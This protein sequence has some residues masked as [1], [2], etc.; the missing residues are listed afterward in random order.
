[1][2]RPDS[3]SDRPDPPLLRQIR[4][5]LHL[6][7]ALQALPRSVTEAAATVAALLLAAAAG[8]RLPIGPAAGVLDRLASPWIALPLFAA[9]LAI[10]LGIRWRRTAVSPLE[11]AIEVDRRLGL[12]ERVSSATL[13][14]AAADPAV[15]AWVAEDAA[16]RTAGMTAARVAP[17]SLPRGW[18]APTA[19]IAAVA[20]LL[21]VDPPGRVPPAA[22]AP[23]ASPAA[24]AVTTQLA[25]IREAI[26]EAEEEPL[27][28]PSPEAPR[29]AA[30]MEASI[31][32]LEAEASRLAAAADSG[33][34]AARREAIEAAAGLGSMAERLD[35][36]ATAREQ[37]IESFAASFEGLDPRDLPP[38]AAG[39]A[40][41]IL[42]GDFDAAAETLESLAGEGRPA[43]GD[44]AAAIDAMTAALAEAADA[45][46]LEPSRDAEV[47]RDEFADRFDA[48]ENAEGSP[49]APD[50]A[51]GL[52]D[53]AGD[54]S[55]SDREPRSSASQN[56]AD[57][58]SETLQ[59]GPE[60]PAAAEPSGPAA[61]PEG[62]TAANS[63]PAAP[64]EPSWL[65]R[66]AE[67]LRDL[68]P[69]PSPA[70]TPAPDATGGAENATEPRET[71][72]NEA[73]EGDASQGPDA[74]AP[75]ESTPAPSPASPVGTPSQ[76]PAGTPPA[77]T[78]ASSPASSDGTSSQPTAGT[79]PSATPAPSP[80]SSEGVASQSP[81][82]TPP[83]ASGESTG[84]R[85]ADGSAS[86]TA[87]PSE[88]PSPSGSSPVARGDA[89]SGSP[90]SASGGSGESAADPAGGG[91]APAGAG[92]GRGRRS[93]QEAARE[94]SEVLRRI[95]ETR[96][97]VEQLR[98]DAQSLDSISRRLADAGSDRPRSAGT[99][100]LP[101]RREFLDAAERLATA[102]A[103]PPR[104]E[105]L[106][107]WLEAPDLPEGTAAEAIAS[108]P[109]AAAALRRAAER[110]IEG[111]AVHPRHHAAV[112]RY[113]SRLE[114]T[115][116]PASSP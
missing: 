45:P 31:A 72:T 115:T 41:Q 8:V 13:A 27:P 85:T 62:E 35:A 51:A 75:P 81:G 49:A 83:T 22:S 71:S 65:D 7:R 16:R 42:Q 44:L 102:A 99:E 108:N 40:E 39:L 68:A 63:P 91:G 111:G 96:R 5:R 90:S 92:A 28:S 58:S 78:P 52:G 18:F 54:A 77:A 70:P 109:A 74:N 3:P 113:F 19:A 80:A 50:A 101:A 36:I 20:L 32:L 17:W 61:S 23:P 29:D 15:R 53:P 104:G 64:S 38:L 33:E 9:I 34:P 46:P 48:A 105:R 84:G 24:I 95:A 67:A 86:P 12:A 98:R 37:A 82:A 110:A 56:A 10:R 88:G 69:T 57:G 107:T 26:E 6:Q 76:T 89:E 21:L 1:M 100:S 114:S 87:R 55:A 93:P 60:M 97:G 112:R 25:A 4:S 94:A 59:D 73:T 66:F 11:A 2:P 43:D 47:S 30:G 103:D 106:A 116:P 79:P 14:D